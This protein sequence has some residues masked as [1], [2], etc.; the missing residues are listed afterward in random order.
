[1]VPSTTKTAVRTALISKNNSAT[2]ASRLVITNLI[3]VVRCVCKINETS[4]ITLRCKNPG[5]CRLDSHT[6]ALAKPLTL[7]AIIRARRRQVSASE[8]HKGAKVSLPGSESLH[9]GPFR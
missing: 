2:A 7:L 8:Q 6:E 1:M 9:G 3:F 5:R 4:E